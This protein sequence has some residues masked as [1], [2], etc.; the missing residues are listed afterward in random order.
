MLERV[1][2]AAQG[3][4][5]HPGPMVQNQTPDGQAS[6]V[7]LLQNPLL[8]SL[9]P[10]QLPYLV[11]HLQVFACFLQWRTAN[12]ASQKGENPS[13]AA[14]E[15]SDHERDLWLAWGDPH[16]SCHWHQSH[17]SGVM[18]SSQHLSSP[19]VL[20]SSRVV[21]FAARLRR[22]QDGL[23]TG[24]VDAVDFISNTYRINFDR[25]GLG[26]H[27]VPDIEVL[28]SGPLATKST[29]PLSCHTSLCAWSLQSNDPQETMPISVFQNQQRVSHPT[30]M[31]TPPRSG[32]GPSSPGLLGVGWMSSC[33]LCIGF[34]IS[35]GIKYWVPWV[36]LT[37]C[38]QDYD[39]LLGSSPLKPTVTADGKCGGFPVRLLV[40]MV[41]F[42]GP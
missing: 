37:S 14:E 28:V 13:A 4:E 40:L 22:P 25:P 19:I 23:F 10:V 31:F 9:S 6:Q 12:F 15:V 38:F 3:K 34:F 8:L 35:V 16:A 36:I 24:V 2:P 20:F 7:G 30:S 26:S 1:L 29:V 41:R 11:H 33:L 39:P 32:L 27:S 42:S 18:G 21:S 5:T 17:R